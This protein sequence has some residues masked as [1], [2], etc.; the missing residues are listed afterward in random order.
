VIRVL[1]Q[2]SLAAY[3]G[4]AGKFNRAHRQRLI[5]VI[6]IVMVL[7]ASISMVLIAGSARGTTVLGSDVAPVLPS[8][9]D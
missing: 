4:T 2:S 7:I 6:S 1:R 5:S 9:L 3:V 8:A